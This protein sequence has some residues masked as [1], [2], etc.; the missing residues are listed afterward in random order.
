MSQ[1]LDSTQNARNRGSECNRLVSNSL[2]RPCSDRIIQAMC[3]TLRPPVKYWGS[4]RGVRT[5]IIMD[6][7]PQ[8]AKSKT[9]VFPVNW[10]VAGIPRIPSTVRRLSSLILTTPR[11]SS[12]SGSTELP[13][14]GWSGSSE[15]PI[16][17]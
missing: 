4:H 8:P 5:T 11:G 16:L 13:P 2:K 6:I 9:V 7:K 3:E 15:F 10:A 1:N 14:S 17:R 12:R